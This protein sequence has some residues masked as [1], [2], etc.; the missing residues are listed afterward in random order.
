MGIESKVE[1]IYKRFIGPNSLGMS[2]NL[3]KSIKRSLEVAITQCSKRQERAIIEKC[4]EG[5]IDLC[6]KNTMVEL[7]VPPGVDA[8]SYIEGWRT[9]Y[10]N[11]M[12]MVNNSGQA[13]YQKSLYDTVENLLE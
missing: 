1:K 4:R 11:I 12:S 13:F 6:Y 9:A 7:A 8:K 10:T 2:K 5:V 3:E